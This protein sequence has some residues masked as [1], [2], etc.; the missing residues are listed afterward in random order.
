MPPFSHGA[1]YS[2]GRNND[3]ITVIF[4]ELRCKYSVQEFQTSSQVLPKPGS[5]FANGSDV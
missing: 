1:R 3:D 5:K 4:A 2:S